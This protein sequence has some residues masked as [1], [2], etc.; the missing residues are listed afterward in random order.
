MK[1]QDKGRIIMKSKNK[2]LIFLGAYLTV[3]VLFLCFCRR[4]MTCC[5]CC[6]SGTKE[7][8]PE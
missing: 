6:G 3:G 5:K 2:L 1:S 4:F 7:E 8:K